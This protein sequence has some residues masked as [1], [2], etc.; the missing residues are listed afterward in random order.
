MVTTFDTLRAAKR[1]RDAGATEQL[2]EAMAETISEGR[3]LDL[4]HLATK[5]DL[6][7]LRAATKADLAGLET[8]LVREIAEAR[9]SMIR[10]ALGTGF[11]QLLAI[12]GSMVGLLKLLGWHP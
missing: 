7:E 8:K 9:V 10:W 1:L 3:A 6:A 11:V 2:A 5:T 12:I 4:A